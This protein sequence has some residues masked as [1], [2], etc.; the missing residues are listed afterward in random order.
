MINCSIED[1]TCNSGML[2]MLHAWKYYNSNGVETEIMNSISLY[3]QF[4]CKVLYE[5]LN[6]LRT[7]NNQIETQSNFIEEKTNV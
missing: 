6:Y 5:I 4:D 1:N 2:V 3:N 7:Y